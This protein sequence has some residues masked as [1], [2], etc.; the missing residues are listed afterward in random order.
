MYYENVLEG[1]YI[2]LKSVREEDAKFTLAIRQDPE[3]TKY[4]PKLDIT[5]GQQKEWIRKQQ[6]KPDDYFFVVYDK[7]EKPIGTYG[8]YDIKVNDTAESGRMAMRGNALQNIEAQLLTYKFAFEKLGLA[9]IYGFIYKSNKRNQRF[10]LQFG[11]EIDETV[12]NMYG[13]M[14]VKCICRKDRFLIYS[15]KLERFLYR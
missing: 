9:S 8:L 13:T 2:K 4:L 6:E 7:E 3:F 10:N 12:I 15:K 11:A 5:V 14:V 1:K